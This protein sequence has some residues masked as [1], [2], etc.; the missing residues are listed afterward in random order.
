MKKTKKTQTKAP[1]KA[2][3]ASPASKAESTPE[4]AFLEA[5]SNF[6]EDDLK[7]FLETAEVDD[8]DIILDDFE[9]AESL[10][11]HLLA[12]C[13][14]GEQADNDEFAEVLIDLGER[15]GDL[16][17]SANGGDPGARREIAAVHEMLDD[18][19]EDGILDG[20]SLMMIAKVLSDAGL[21][22]PKRLKKASLSL[23][24]SAP[25]SEADDEAGPQHL[26]DSL[27]ELSEELEN[28]EFALFEQIS[29]MFE[30]FPAEAAAHFVGNLVALGRGVCDRAI[31]GFALHREAAVATA[32]LDALA[33]ISARPV[34]SLVI[35]RLVRMRPWVA[36]DR[37][38][39][40]DAAIK[41]LRQSAKAPVKAE[42]GTVEKVFLSV[43]DG[44][45]AHQIVATTR[46]G[47]TRS[48]LALLIKLDGV[49]DLAVLEDLK[50]ADADGVLATLKST[51]PIAETD[52]ATATR[53]LSLALADNLASG[54]PPPYQLV[55][56]VERLGLGPVTPR[57][58]TPAEIAADCL[59]DTSADPEALAR[60]YREIVGSE[61]TASWFE[62]GEAVEDLLAATRTRQQRV[63]KLLASYLPQRRAFWARQCAISAL[64]LSGAAGRKP[65]P[66]ALSLALIARELA[67]DRP[68]DEIPVM[69]EIAGTTA[70]AFAHNARWR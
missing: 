62:A 42:T 31:V 40:L 17:V 47:R 41:A 24:E 56:F 7:R 49:A 63:K 68:V 14:E 65:E 36:A 4:E 45:G 19:L 55:R 69:R 27:A 35:E 57:H 37:R 18:A 60:A 10:F 46:N 21:K 32:A 43:C 25:Q 34:E 5:L 26:L 38:P 22:V 53:M 3:K 61:I 54:V 58:D 33:G 9:D 48:V 15:L 70:T 50:K 23:L 6:S 16:R 66:Y 11:S 52:I 12:L 30:A 20:A 8:D 2:K 13:E 39:S 1:A 51:T 67:S 44:A 59:G 29:S 28:D 64:A